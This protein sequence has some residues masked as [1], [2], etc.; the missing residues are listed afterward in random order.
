MKRILPAILSSGA[1]LL[2]LAAVPARASGGGGVIYFSQSNMPFTFKSSATTVTKVIQGQIVDGVCE[3]PL[4]L[5]HAAGAGPVGLAEV[6]FDPANCQE[7]VMTGPVDPTGAH[8]GES[9]NTVTCGHQCGSGYAATGSYD[10]WWEDPLGIHVTEVKQSVGWNY[11]GTYVDQINSQSETATPYTNSGW[12]VM[13]NQSGGAFNNNDT[14]YT[15]QSNVSFGNTEFCGGTWSYYNPQ[16]LNA[17]GSGTDSGYVNTY[18]SG[19]DTQYLHVYSQL[20]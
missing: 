7:T 15:Y 9:P 4:T 17:F 11:D 13:S 2:A 19:C 18:N 16:D 5:T 20:N 3:V 10:V 1:L 14:E 6:A 8:G 12:Y